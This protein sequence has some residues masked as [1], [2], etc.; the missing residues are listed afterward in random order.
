MRM[1]T[2]TRT[3][4]RGR[5]RGRGRGGEGVGRRQEERERRRVTRAQ[6]IMATSDGPLTGVVQLRPEDAVH[7]EYVAEGAAHVVFTYV[8]PPPPDPSADDSL[9]RRHD[10]RVM[11]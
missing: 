1:R 10:A 8:G 11:H 3:R 7:W 5:G 4:T 2:R 9:V 6:E